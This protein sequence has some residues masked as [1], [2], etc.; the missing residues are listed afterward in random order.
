MVKHN[1][2]NRNV[3]P[4]IEQKRLYKSL[5]GAFKLANSSINVRHK[6]KIH[7]L[8]IALFCK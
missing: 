1:A 6:G 5:R 7:S 2:T 8:N 3:F 4:L